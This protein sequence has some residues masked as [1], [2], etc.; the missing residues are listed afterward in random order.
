MEDRST[1]CAQPAK[2]RYWR[3]RKDSFETVRLDVLRWLRKDPDSTTKAL[4]EHFQR[5]HTGTLPIFY[6]LR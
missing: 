2:P 3:T 1:H 5:E 4:F 6:L